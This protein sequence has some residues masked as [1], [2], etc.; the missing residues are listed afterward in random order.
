MIT[1]AER[2]FEA[3]LQDALPEAR[4][5]IASHLSDPV[6]CED[7]LSVAVTRAWTY[8]G[9]RDVAEPFEPR[10]FTILRNVLRHDQRE[11]A[12]QPFCPTRP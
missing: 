9:S 2:G 10:L 7:V 6:E 5:R 8:R 11:L 4:R 1:P 3:A 12:H